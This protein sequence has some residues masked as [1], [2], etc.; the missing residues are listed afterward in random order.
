MVMVM[1]RDVLSLP[2]HAADGDVTVQGSVT[3]S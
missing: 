1:P 2:E 3:T